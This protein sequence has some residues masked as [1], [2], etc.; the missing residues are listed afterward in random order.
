MASD[1][2]DITSISDKRN[3]IAADRLD[4]LRANPGRTAQVSVRVGRHPYV[5]YNAERECFES[6]TVTGVGYVEVE[7]CDEQELLSLF[8][9]NPVV[10]KPIDE[11]TYS[12]PKPGESLLWQ[13]VD[14]DVEN[15]TYVDS[16]GGNE[17]DTDGEDGTS[18]TSEVDGE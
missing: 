3:E 8:V 15:V 14:D 17:D 10:V 7:T 2:A 6:T 5:R 12:P 1:D 4:E 13:A 16:D 18:D 11:A 9:A